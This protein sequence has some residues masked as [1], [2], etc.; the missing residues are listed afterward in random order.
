MKVKTTRPNNITEIGRFVAAIERGDIRGSA[1][2]IDPD[3]LGLHEWNDKVV[4]DL[5]SK[6]PRS[7]HVT[8]P[9]QTTRTCF[10]STNIH[11]YTVFRA[12]NASPSEAGGIEHIAYDVLQ[13]LIKLKNRGKGLVDSI[14]ELANYLTFNQRCI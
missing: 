12:L 11:N 10:R 1:N 14:T 2:I 13:K 9:K 6:F 4:R 5:I 3:N 8:E 7:D